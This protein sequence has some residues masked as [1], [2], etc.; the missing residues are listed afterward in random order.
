MSVT[1]VESPGIILAELPFSMFISFALINY[2]AVQF[3]R[4]ERVSKS[5][6]GGEQER[7]IAKGC[8]FVV[9]LVW[10]KAHCTQ[11]PLESPLGLFTKLSNFCSAK[12]VNPANSSISIEQG[13]GRRKLTLMINPLAQREQVVIF[14]LEKNYRM[15]VTQSL[16]ETL[17]LRNLDGKL[18]KRALNWTL[19]NSFV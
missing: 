16:N 7:S 8:W 10:T 1:P 9:E 17:F 13:N 12:V 4:L 11:L 15:E 5:S 14:L 19:L 18:H 6:L 3:E 2:S